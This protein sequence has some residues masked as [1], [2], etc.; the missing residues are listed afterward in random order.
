MGQIY[1]IFIIYNTLNLNPGAC[2]QNQEGA[3]EVYLI[4]LTSGNNT[5]EYL[6]G[7]HNFGTALVI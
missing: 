5:T 6:F 1:S 3:E 4:W 7:K 2:S